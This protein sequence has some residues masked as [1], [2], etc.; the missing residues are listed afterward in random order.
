MAYALTET[1]KRLGAIPEQTWRESAFPSTEQLLAGS[2]EK[3]S[4]I[5]ADRPAY[6][7]V[8]SKQAG[9]MTPATA[10]QPA[11]FTYAPQTRETI[12]P[13]SE[14]ARNPSVRYALDLGLREGEQ[15]SSIYKSASKTGG[16]TYE[17]TGTG[18]GA[19]SPAQQ[20]RDIEMKSRG[21]VTDIYGNWA[22]A[23]GWGEVVD[24][25]A[26]A[27]G[28]GRGGV[29]QAAEPD[30]GSMTIPQLIAYGVKNK[31]TARAQTQAGELGRT[32]AS[33]A[34]ALERAKI[35]ERGAIE[36]ASVARQPT[37]LELA[38]AKEVEARTGV[39]GTEKAQ[40][41]MALRS[42]KRDEVAQEMVNNPQDY[43][44]EQ[45]AQ[46]RAHLQKKFEEQKL[47]ALIKSGQYEEP[48][49]KM[50]DGGAVH[51]FA[52]GGAIT[53]PV[54]QTQQ[55]HP[56]IAQYGQYLTA[57]ASAGVPP[58]P[59]NQYMNLLQTTRGAMQTTPAQFA[60][61]GDVSALGRPL[62]G[63]GTGR[64]D[65]IPATINGS[66]PAA[67]SDGEFVI[68]AHVVKAKGTEFFEKL[69][70]QYDEGQK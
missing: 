16:V 4:N 41:E 35:G 25:Y 56:A 66:Q 67:L 39:L 32:A 21:M 60:D 52:D 1:E 20:Q 17:G 28:A 54:T 10:T 13:V 19:V 50:A 64:S 58:V 6:S 70:A 7:P 23:G 9:A 18:T 38:Q 27:T 47:L 65:S 14:M 22:P 11:R 51:G 8:F 36:R 31:Q 49:A 69:L 3:V 42:A 62:Q 34:G 44:P 30:I 48:V 5:A 29:P 46:A 12:A 57:A 63:P 61:G 59:F 24:R 2:R 43:K 37:A 55:M 26:S 33:E 15:P 53:E 40:K 68:P 45:V